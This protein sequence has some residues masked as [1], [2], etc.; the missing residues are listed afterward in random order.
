MN[1]LLNGTS[2]RSSMANWILNGNR[3]GQFGIHS[4]LHV[5]NF[6]WHFFCA[7]PRKASS[8]LDQIESTPIYAYKHDLYVSVC[9]FSSLNLNGKYLWLPSLS[10]YSTYC[11]IQISELCANASFICCRFTQWY[12]CVLCVCVCGESIMYY[13]NLEQKEKG[14]SEM[15]NNGTRTQLAMATMNL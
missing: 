12:E 1:S 3:S 15:C 11:S 6:G 10:L 9:R 5:H 2:T 13:F 7:A 4:S 14:S 8:H